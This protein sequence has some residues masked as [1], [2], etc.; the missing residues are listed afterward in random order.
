[1]NQAIYFDNK[2]QKKNETEWGYKYNSEDEEDL[3]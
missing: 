1:M 3:E 2:A